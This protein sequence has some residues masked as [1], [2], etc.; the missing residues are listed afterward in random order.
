M[1]I[2]KPSS[3]GPVHQQNPNVVIT[4]PADALALYISGLSA[5]T[6]LA[7]KKTLMFPS[8]CS[9]LPIIQ[10]HLDGLY[11]TFCNDKGDVGKKMRHF[12][13]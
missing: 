6:V 12:E 10:F 8:I 2:I 5:G 4:V 9:G 3:A 13:C 11:D 1:L 7:E